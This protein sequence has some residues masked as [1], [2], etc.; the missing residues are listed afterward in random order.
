MNSDTLISICATSNRHAPY[1]QGIPMNRYASGVK[2]IGLVKSDIDE[3]TYSVD[4]IETIAKHCDIFSITHIRVDYD[5]SGNIADVLKCYAIKCDNVKHVWGDISDRLMLAGDMQFF[6]DTHPTDYVKHYEGSSVFNTYFDYLCPNGIYSQFIRKDIS[7]ASFLLKLNKTD[8]IEIKSIHI[9]ANFCYLDYDYRRKLA[10]H[11]NTTNINIKTPEQTDFNKI[12][13]NKYVCNRTHTHASGNSKKTTFIQI[14]GICNGFF[15][16]TNNNGS[17]REIKLITNSTEFLCL[18]DK[19]WINTYTTRFG[20]WLYIPIDTYKREI[21]EMRD[22]FHFNA[23][24]SPDLS[25]IDC[26][27]VAISADTEIEY[28]D[29]A[30]P[31]HLTMCVHDVYGE[32]TPINMQ[33]AKSSGLLCECYPASLKYDRYNYFNFYEV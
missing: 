23:N 11:Y 24:G 10:T 25:R 2:S 15:I 17:L 31:L 29:Y 13:G 14:N 6:K 18:S 1:I 22:C 9:V 3:L 16:K 7:G 21:K 19:V 8:G 27:T 5:G 12:Y 32:V 33:K 30:F 28:V 4:L 20:D 26:F